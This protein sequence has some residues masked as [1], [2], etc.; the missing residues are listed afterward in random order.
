MSKIIDYIDIELYQYL[1]DLKIIGSLS[2]LFSN[3]SIPILNYRA[4]ENIYCSIFDA[5]NISRCDVSIDAKY[6]KLGTQSFGVG[7][8]TFIEGNKA[9]FQKIAEF[10]KQNQF[11]KD[12]SVKDKII[13]IAELRNKRLE[14][15]KNIY[16]IQRFIYHC[17]VRNE[18]GF[19]LFEEEIDFIDIPKIKISGEKN[20][21]IAFTDGIC[22]YQF[23]ESKST[24]YKRFRTIE[25]F[26][27]VGVEIIEDPIKELRSLNLQEL[28]TEPK[29]ME[30]IIIPLFSFKRKNAEKVVEIKSGLNQWNAKPR[31]NK[32]GYHARNSS[33]VYIPYP[34]VLRSHF[35]NF[36]PNRD[37][38][39][40][41]IL[42]S[43]E[44]ISMKICQEDGKAIM[45]NPNKALG[46]WL[47]RD[48][49]GLK[50]RQLLTYNDLL[51]IGIDAVKFE[52]YEN[53]YKLN[54][55]EV[56]VFDDF[57]VKI[58]NDVD[59]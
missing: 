38:P 55:V 8:K 31:K 7:I 47:L 23:Y 12:L 26:A 59:I 18:K 33:E 45:S 49:L 25:Y 6:K 39:F 10:N 30:Y 34:K 28:G 50:E 43:G 35:E 42:P 20:S 2:R 24:L 58:F 44:E 14:V 4:T 46:K 11:Y 56:G 53:T 17:I 5:E 57:M 41:V 52:K 27:N 54:F 13:K 22:E 19:F 37:T 32:Q 36:F 48:V 29:Y 16:N 1:N 51:E 15:T 3:S 21:V 9:S 40:D